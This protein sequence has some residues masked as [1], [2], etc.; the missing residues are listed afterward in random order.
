MMVIFL[1]GVLTGVYVFTI[2]HWTWE[3]VLTGF[4]L[5]GTLL[6]IFRKIMFAGPF[7]SN[8]E[9]VKVIVQT[10]RYILYLIRDII[11]GTWQ[12]ATYV[13]GLRKLEHPGIIRI[14]FEEDSR[15]RLGIALVAIT[16]SPGSFVVDV[17][18]EERFVLVHLIDISDAEKVRKELRRIYFDVP[19]TRRD[20]R[21]DRLHA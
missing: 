14:H 9:V 1:L 16:I 19:G 6:W 10:P 11:T 3:D 21:E 7:V 2:G 15:V 8:R 13:V 17:N 4:L 18:H 5:S 20:P 12:V